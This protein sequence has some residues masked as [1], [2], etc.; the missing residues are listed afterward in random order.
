MM[1]LEA[2]SIVIY[3]LLIFAAVSVQAAYAA[4]TGGL[5][6]GFSNRECPQPGMGPAGLRIDRTLGNLKEGAIMYLP[7][8]LLA[9]GLNISNGWTWGAAF[10]TIVSRLI[11]VPVFY[12]G[13]PVVRTMVWAP[14]FVAI[15]LL[16]VGI[17]VGA[18]GALP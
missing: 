13:I 10:L 8:A 17:L 1:T 7:L 15:P 14:S 12:L 18:T 16:S 2:L 9:V 6:F 4:V 11:Y 3:A 5:A